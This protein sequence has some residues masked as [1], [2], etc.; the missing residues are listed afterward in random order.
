MRELMA[1]GLADQAFLVNAA[2]DLAGGDE[3]AK[4]TA[5]G[6]YNTRIKIM[7]AN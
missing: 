4:L 6:V 2:A 7:E 1:R 5:Q 3:A